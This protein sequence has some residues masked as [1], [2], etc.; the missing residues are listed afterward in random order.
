MQPVAGDGAGAGGRA[1]DVGQRV[2]IVADGQEDDGTLGIL[3]ARPV[4]AKGEDGEKGG[5]ETDAGPRNHPGLG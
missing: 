3:E 1:Q 2:E 4:H 5:D